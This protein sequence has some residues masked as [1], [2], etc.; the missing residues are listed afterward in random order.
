[1][2]NKSFNYFAGIALFAMFL[3]PA[4]AD[5]FCNENFCNYKINNTSIYFSVYT[6]GVTG[7]QLIAYLDAGMCDV[8]KYPHRSSDHELCKQYAHADLK[9][10]IYAL[11]FPVST[12]C[13]TLEATTTYNCINNYINSYRKHQR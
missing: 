1:M 8:I 2:K 3:N 5:N 13:T 9:L 7:K 12:S 4:K 11:E 10:S 6:T